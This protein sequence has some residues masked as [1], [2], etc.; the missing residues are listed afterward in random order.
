MKLQKLQEYFVYFKDFAVHSWSGR[1]VVHQKSIFGGDQINRLRRP[2]KTPQ[3]FFCDKHISVIARKWE[4]PMRRSSDLCLAGDC[5]SRNETC[6]PKDPSVAG[7]RQKVSLSALTAAV[8]SGI[9][10]R[11]SCSAAP[12]H[13]RVCHAMG[14]QI[15]ETIIAP[16]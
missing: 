9:F 3:P 16:G 10:T 15:V 13:R 14:Y 2:Q 1:S 6:L 11:L 5:Y 4:N 12:V 8:P 7:F